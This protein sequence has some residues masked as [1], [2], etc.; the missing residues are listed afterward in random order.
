MPKQKLTLSIDQDIIKEA[1]KYDINISSFLEV[2]LIDF[3][4]G[5]RNV[6]SHRGVYKFSPVKMFDKLQKRQVIN[7]STFLS[8]TFFF[9]F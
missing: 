2:R 5:K 8:K 7:F 9:F 3:L 1:K 4:N 6:C